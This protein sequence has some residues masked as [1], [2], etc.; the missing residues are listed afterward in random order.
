MPPAVKVPFIVGIVV[1]IVLAVGLLHDAQLR[2]SH[3]HA[4]PRPVRDS[5]TL[6][7]VFGAVSVRRLRSSRRSRSSSWL[8][9]GLRLYFVV[10]ALGFP[11]VAWAFRGLFV[12]LIGSLLH[13]PCRSQPA[14]CGFA[15]AGV[16]GVLTVVYH[17]PL[18]GGDRDWRPVE[19]ER[20]GVLSIIV[21]GA[22]QFYVWSRRSRGARAAVVESPAPS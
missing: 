17:V 4:A 12:A 8:T 9:E 16:V 15:Q 19:L 18:C 10:Q 6:E 13:R 14:A 3:P 5:T 2:T 20:V 7:G 22:D 11:D 1:V 21:L